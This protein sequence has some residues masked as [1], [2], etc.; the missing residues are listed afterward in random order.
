MGQQMN[1]IIGGLKALRIQNLGLISSGDWPIKLLL[2]NYKTL[3][4]LDLGTETWLGQAYANHTC[5]ERFRTPYLIRKL[6]ILINKELKLQGKAKGSVFS[7]ETLR[8]DSLD[9]HFIL[10]GGIGLVID[11]SDL[12]SLHLGSCSGLDKA[13]AQ[14]Y[15]RD[16]LSID[17]LGAF[18]ALAKLKTF[19]LRHERTTSDV[20]HQLEAFSCSLPPLIKFK[21]FSRASRI[22]R[23]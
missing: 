10:G 7:L 6:G 12:T 18:G 11:F 1:P 4:T 8:L 19:I 15:N 23:A 21:F 17:T 2:R 20:K 14:L 3:R 5:W 9:L 13:F 16:I 22:L